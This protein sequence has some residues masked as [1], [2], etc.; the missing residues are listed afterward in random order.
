MFHQKIVEA[1]KI[2]KAETMELIEIVN[3]I[4]IW[5]QLNIPRIEDGNNFGVSIQGTWQTVS[6]LFPDFFTTPSSLLYYFFL[7]LSLSLCSAYEISHSL[8]EE[9]VNELGRAEESSFAILENM[10]KYYVNRAKL[11]TK[12]RSHK[13]SQQQQHQQPTI[14]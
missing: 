4:K 13:C 11:V 5:I 2:V 14:N 3:N 7:S 9:T 8:S 1:L 6:L 10:T 12:V